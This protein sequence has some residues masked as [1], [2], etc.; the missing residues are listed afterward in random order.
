MSEDRQIF[1][2][3]A[4][5]PEER[6]RRTAR[7]GEKQRQPKPPYRTPLSLISAIV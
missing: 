4:T 6:R 2:A 3:T 1:A 7:E 5:G